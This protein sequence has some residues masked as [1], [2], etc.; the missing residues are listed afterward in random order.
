MDGL[1]W[2]ALREMDG[3][4]VEGGTSNLAG[5]G[6]CLP[7]TFSLSERSILDAGIVFEGE[8]GAE[9]AG[10][11]QYEFAFANKGSESPSP[12]DAC[13]LSGVVHARRFAHFWHAMRRADR[14][15]LSHI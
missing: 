9:L 2:N 4:I 5:S 1:I 14:R 8:R 3:E 6:S 12:C 10:V 7:L 13:A 15:V 11:R